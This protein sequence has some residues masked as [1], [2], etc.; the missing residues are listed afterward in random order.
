MDEIYLAI[1]ET[2]RDLRIARKRVTELEKQ[3]AMQK[4]APN[5]SE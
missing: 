1:Y 3:L 4:A 2:K 5:P